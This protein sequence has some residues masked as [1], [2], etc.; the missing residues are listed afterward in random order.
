VTRAAVLAV[1]AVAAA[2]AAG[3]GCGKKG[4]PL[5]PLRP[6]P[7]AVADF[8]AER[9][10]ER[11]TLRFAVP[12]ANA[13][14]TTPVAIDR[15]EIYAVTLADA[16]K[17]PAANQAAVAANL[18]A[19]IAVQ[20]A[21][22]DTPA[23]K[24]APK[25]PAPGEV[26]QHVDAV[27]L[28]PDAASTVARAYVAVP[29][30]GRRRAGMSPV[31]VVPLAGA[32]AAAPD[33]IRI[34]YTED[35]VTL[36]WDAGTAGTRFIVERPAAAGSAPLRL[37]PRPTEQTTMS[38][39]M[40]LGREV[41]VTLRAVTATGAV[42]LVS[43][44]SR[45]TCE[46]PTDKFP[47]EA[48]SGLVGTAAAGAID[49]VWRPSINKDVAGYV[50]LRAEGAGGTLQR[51]TPV[52]LTATTYRDSAVRPGVTYEYVVMAVDTAKPANESAPSNR[53]SVTAR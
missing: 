23:P 42:A 4:P 36:T 47:P 29:A 10:G 46:T 5:P 19:T 40:E 32:S 31:L 25:L 49:L 7:A 17:P 18:L 26:V 8:S 22:S 35:L 41:C 21:P 24:T 13:D 43:E 15:V 38:L 2:G 50:V 27:K 33:P 52:P 9:D 51:L 30:V 45:A 34:T 39:P 53:E 14:G 44:P 3:A 20:P 1:I 6:V 16:A 37:T 11:V 48:P 12:K 28:L